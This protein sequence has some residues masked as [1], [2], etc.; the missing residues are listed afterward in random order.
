VRVKLLANVSL[1]PLPHDGV[2]GGRL[3]CE[4]DWSDIEASIESAATVETDLL[5]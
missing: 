3:P 4:G 5:I 2:P 1:K